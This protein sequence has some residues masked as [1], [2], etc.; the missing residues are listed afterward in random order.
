M[1]KPESFSRKLL[2]PIFF[3]LPFSTLIIFCFQKGRVIPELNLKNYEDLRDV[4]GGCNSRD[5]TG[6]MATKVQ[7]MI[8][9]CAK[10]ATDKV[11]IIVILLNVDHFGM[12]QTDDINRMITVVI[13]LFF[14]YPPHTRGIVEVS[15]FMPFGI[16]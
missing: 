12:I 14:T 5:V 15:F 9:L 1:T 2:I 8:D 11:T 7:N 4:I 3:A 13:C 6:G 16:G 10:E